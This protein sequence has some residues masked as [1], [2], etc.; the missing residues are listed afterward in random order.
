MSH[1]FKVEQAS[2]RS[3][4]IR[5]IGLMLMGF[6][7]AFLILMRA[8]YLQLVKNP[9]L[10]GISRRQFQSR[11]LIR[12]RRGLIL[13][14]NG[15]PLAVNTEANSLAANPNKVRNKARTARLLA[16]AINVP[17]DKVFHKLSEKREFIWI[18]RH[19]QATDLKR[20]KG[21]RLVDTE[22]DLTEGLWL[23]K[24]S[25]RIYPRGELAAHIVGDVNVDSDGLEGVEL[26]KNEHL[27]G[28]IT[29]MTAIKDAWGRPTFIDAVAAQNI[30][31]GE[32][33]S[34][35]LDSL[36]QFEV[37]QK[38]SAAVKRTGAQSGTVIVMDAV[39]GEIL[40][41][42]NEPTFNPNDRRSDRKIPPE[43]RRNRAVTDGY[44]PGSTFKAI[45]AAGILSHGGRLSDQVW[46]ERGSFLVQGHRISE[47]EAR[48]KFE[49]VSLKKMIQVSSNVGA[50]KFA[51]R[52]GSL[53]YLQ[54]IQ[55]FGF[56]M[57]SNLGFPGEIS[58]RIPADKEWTPLTLAN[59]GFGQGL[60]V[61]PLQ[62]TRAYAAILNGGWLIRP[63]LIKSPFKG[64][65]NKN[66]LDDV[67]PR[68]FSQ[69]VS[70][71]L[72]EALESVTEE[73]GTGV[74]AALEGYR[75][76]G[77]TGTA[78]WVDPKLKKYS[79]DQYISSFIGFPI[80][81]D[82]KVV[83]FASLERPQGSYYAAETAV[84]LF[85][86]VL[87]SVA[88]RCELPVRMAS[89]KLLARQDIQDLSK[90]NRASALIAAD[91]KLHPLDVPLGKP[92]RWMMPELKGLT[93]REAIRA[94]QGHRLALEISGNGIVSSQTPAAGQPIVEGSFVRLKLVEP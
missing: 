85:K 63:K 12:P 54:M 83:I 74:K 43:R 40:A 8:G 88:N 44:E 29:S 25:D 27:R 4:G 36:L 70:L 75:V 59:V 84:P 46:G 92:Q 10:D 6:G 17:V 38:L 81:V 9:R 68:I 62:M 19:L 58:G 13:D 16:R 71:K 78:Q 49:W 11:V 51:L 28:E 50:A 61:T 14:R 89:R 76:A 87:I 73:G 33:V 55:A 26:W 91:L 72:I 80:D 30:H 21:H 94:F 93:S 31:D 2:D 22:G 86:E 79:K 52:L 45:L 23:V 32:A 35:T 41:M 53:S 34:L 24:E 82:P 90:T 69:N 56:G 77:K 15:E 39:N 64:S 42:A 67:P 1:D 48:E 66:P 47:A 20:L 65:E 5:L 57:K 37:E 18:K 60:L 7:I 3:L